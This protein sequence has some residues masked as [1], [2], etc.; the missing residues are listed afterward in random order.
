[1]CVGAC[2]HVSMCACV[3]ACCEITHLSIA[4]HDLSLCVTHRVGIDL[5][6]AVTSTSDRIRRHHS[7]TR[8]LTEV[9]LNGSFVALLWVHCVLCVWHGV[10]W[11]GECR[12]PHRAS[13]APMVPFIE[14][15]HCIQD[16]QLGPNGVLYRDVPL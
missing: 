7:F 1:M 2:V 6:V 4:N 9:P 5:P 11:C 14:M 12:E 13:W 15:F 3:S 10:V 16:S 8:P